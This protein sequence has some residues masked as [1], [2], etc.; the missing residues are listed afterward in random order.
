M[1]FSRLKPEYRIH[2]WLDLMSLGAACPSERWRSVAMGRADK[3]GLPADVLDIGIAGDASTWSS[4]ALGALAVAVDCFRTGMR[5]PIP[6]FPGLSYAVYRGTVT[7]G[8]WS[9][10]YPYQEGGSPSVVLA[11]GRLEFNEVMSLEPR[12]G[13][14]GDAG[15]RVSRFAHYLFG[16]MDDSTAPWTAAPSA[17]AAGRPA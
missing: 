16:A 7:P 6:F 10:K 13:D 4:T 1:G 12:P 14:P 15:H 17:G 9:T 3:A 8:D 2:A 5:E 11:H